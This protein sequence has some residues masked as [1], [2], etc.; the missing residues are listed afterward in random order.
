MS[1]VRWSALGLAVM[2]VVLLATPA[3]AARVV[4][5]FRDKGATA[6]VSDCPAANASPG[7]KCVAFV[8]TAS[9]LRVRENGEVTRFPSLSLE[10]FRVTITDT[11]FVAVPVAFGVA[12]NVKLSV[13]DNLS[14]ASA[15]GVVPVQQCDRNGCRTTNYPVSFSLHANA[16][17]TS[18]SGRDVEKMGECKIIDR[19][20]F[21]SRTADGSATVRGKTYPTSPVVPSSIDRSAEKVVFKN[22]DA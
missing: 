19:F 4:I 15:S 7:T 20:N 22:C 10:K 3:S 21:V 11:G 16:P 1:K 13:A 17:A 14:S 12:D 2:S 6:V 18:N 9:K 8:A 5:K